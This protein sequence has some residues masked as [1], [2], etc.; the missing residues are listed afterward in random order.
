MN[1]DEVVKDKVQST[2]ASSK[3]YNVKTGG[4]GNHKT[5]KIAPIPMLQ[6]AVD[7]DTSIRIK[8]S[9]V[10]RLKLLGRYGETFDDIIVWLLEHSKRRKL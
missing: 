8:Q 9:T 10:Q 1:P 4:R 3:A 7:K 6:G 2:T 5:G